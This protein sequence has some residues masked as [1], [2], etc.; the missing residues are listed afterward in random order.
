MLAFWPK[1][2]LH[3]SSKGKKRLV[4]KTTTHSYVVSWGRLLN[5]TQLKTKYHITALNGCLWFEGERDY[6]RSHLHIECNACMEGDI[7]S[8][9]AAAQ[10]QQFV[11]VVMEH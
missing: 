2:W 1:N 8:F 4:L 5:H 3:S 11:V 9:F 6:F 10:Q 7:E